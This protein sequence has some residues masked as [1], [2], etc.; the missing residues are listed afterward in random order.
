MHSFN[1]FRDLFMH[2]FNRIKCFRKT[3]FTLYNVRQVHH[4]V[5]DIP[6]AHKEVLANSF[7]NGLIEGP[8][9]ATLVMDPV[10]DYDELLARVEKFIN[11]EE[12]MRIKRAD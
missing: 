12:A 9:F 6:S 1:Q 3:S 10:E 11:L 7:V 4:S 2:Q 8:F 5:L